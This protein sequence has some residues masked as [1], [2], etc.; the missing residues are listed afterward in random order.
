MANVQTASKP[1]PAL[2]RPVRVLAF[3]AWR[4]AEAMGLVDADGR[5]LEQGDVTRLVHRVREV[6]I[7]RDRA[8]RFDNVEIPSP[9]EVSSILR[10]VIAALEASP[11]PRYEWPAVSRVLDA[12]QLASLLGISVSSL[13]RYLSGSRETP[14]EVAA[15][16]HHLALIVGDLAGVYNDVGIRRWFNRRRTPLNDK[17]P[18]ALLAGEWSPEEAGP[19]KVRALAQS[20]V[21]LSAT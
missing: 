1:H 6:G 19:Q 14:D 8:L 4:R 20:V 11:V 10:V 3:E 2:T 18:A 16:L 17:T 15:R 9:E 13:R 7:A 21:T 12:D 5:R